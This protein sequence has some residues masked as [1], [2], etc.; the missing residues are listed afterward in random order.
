MAGVGRI[1]AVVTQGDVLVHTGD[2]RLVCLEDFLIR[3]PLFG[4]VA[5]VVVLHAHDFKKAGFGGLAAIDVEIVALDLEF[6]PGCTGQAFNVVGTRVGFRLDGF[7]IAGVKNED[8]ATRRFAEVV[9]NF[10]NEDEIAS[11]DVAP[12]D[13]GPCGEDRIE[14]EGTNA[15]GRFLVRELFQFFP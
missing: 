7:D 9:G 4:F 8:L 1:I 3:E 11:I 14:V 15:P 5:A 10:V 2:L 6:I 12:G 13:D